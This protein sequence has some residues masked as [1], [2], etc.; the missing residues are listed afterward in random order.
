MEICLHYSQW[1]LTS[2]DSN[3]HSVSDYSNCRLCCVAM[4]KA[5]KGAV[6]RI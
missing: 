4:V 2:L 1:M 6:P 5:I 3:K